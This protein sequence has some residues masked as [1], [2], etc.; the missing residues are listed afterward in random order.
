MDP[1]HPGTLERMD[2]G[3]LGTLDLM[4]PPATQG[5]GSPGTLGQLIESLASSKSAH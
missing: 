4:G 5:G 2:L 1:G 3:P